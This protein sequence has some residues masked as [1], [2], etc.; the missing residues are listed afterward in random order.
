MQPRAENPPSEKHTAYLALGTNLGNRLLNLKTA[1]EALSE[2]VRLVASSPVYETPPWGILDQP[3]FLNQVVQVE[4]E[5]SP[6]DLLRYLKRLEMHMGRVPAERYGPRLIDIDILFYDQR[7]VEMR[8]LRIP[9]PHLAERAFVLV[10]LA[11]LAPDLRHPA[12]GKTISNMLAHTDASGIHL[13]SPG[14]S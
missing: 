8:T 10:P 11:D 3:A 7:M 2:R 6:S 4:T 5:L 9:H 1:R 13:F 14:E 12:T